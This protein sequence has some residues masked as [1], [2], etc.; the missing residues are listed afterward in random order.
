MR[1]TRPAELVAGCP[2]PSNRSSTSRS[3]ER[4]GSNAR[5]PGL[6]QEQ[7]ALDT[8]LHRNY[9][10]ACERGEVNVAFANLLLLCALAD[11]PVSV[12][13]TAE[14]ASTR[15]GGARARWRSSHNSPGGESGKNPVP[16][17]ATCSFRRSTWCEAYTSPAAPRR[18]A[19]SRTPANHTHHG[20]FARPPLSVAS[21]VD[22]SLVG[23]GGLSRGAGT[24]RK[25]HAH[26]VSRMATS[27]QLA[28]TNS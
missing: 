14:S 10:G 28:V 9:V 19:S 21:L 15:V 8:G 24:R 17:R 2:P 23:S 12:T 5:P 6:T 25:C 3:G 22:A 7:L 20:R 11:R 4:C 26:K 1:W 18:L 16:R 13:T 27:L